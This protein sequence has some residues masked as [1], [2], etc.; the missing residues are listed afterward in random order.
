[1]GFSDLSTGTAAIKMKA[2]VF[3]SRQP[4]I[5]LDLGLLA[6]LHLSA[7][8]VEPD[9]LILLVAAHRAL[10]DAGL[11]VALEIALQQGASQATFIHRLKIPVRPEDLRLATAC[12]LMGVTAIT[13]LDAAYPRNLTALLG[14]TAPPILYAKGDLTLPSAPGV[15]LIGMRNPTVTGLAAA[16]RYARAAALHG[17]SVVSGNARGVDAAAHG[18]ALAGGGSTIVFPPSPPEQ[19]QPSFDVPADTR[20]LMLTPFPPGSM[21]QPY[22]FLRRNELVAA[23]ACATVVIE[24]GLRGGTLN[25]VSHLRR[26]GGMWFVTRLRSDHKHHRAHASLIAAGGIP[27]SIREPKRVLHYIS[28]LAGRKPTG[29]QPTTPDLFACEP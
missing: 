5:D 20:V 27:C 13:R 14:S 12:L 2:V 22:F 28:N 21:I 25:T 18:A 26:L 10:G 19:Y 17:F 7:M 4:R 9:E 23:Q 29:P 3:S 8:P 1:M 16:R 6:P 15:G 11:A 24:T